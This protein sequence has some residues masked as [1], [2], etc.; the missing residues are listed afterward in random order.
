MNTLEIPVK[1]IFVQYP[2]DWNE[3]TQKQAVFAGDLLYKVSNQKIDI[4]QFRKLMVDKFIRRVNNKAPSLNID[5]ELDLWGN[6]YLLAETVN[7][8]FK[9]TKTGEKPVQRYRKGVVK[10]Q[11]K[12]PASDDD[13]DIAGQT[14]P[15]ADNGDITNGKE[16]WEVMPTLT[17]NP[18]PWCKTGLFGK[19]LYGPGDFLQ[20][21]TFAEYKDALA[22]S[23]KYMDT[24]NDEWLDRL[25]AILYRKKITGLKRLMKQPDFDGKIRVPY[26]QN[27]TDV[28]AVKHVKTGIKYMA[29][30]YMMGCLWTL[31]NTGEGNE[32]EIDGNKF[33]FSILFTGGK[34]TDDNNDTVGMIGVMMAIAES[35]VF[36]NLK[37]VA[38]TDVWDVLV[39][40][41]QL[42]LDRREFEKRMS[43]K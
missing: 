5:D 12:P 17:K 18:I 13:A 32:I 39:R 9:I 27:K 1:K 33:D 40:M 29:L 4:D 30:M 24:N 6:D 23:M 37:D 43:E 2:S 42:E 11:D 34:N 3:L 41:Y 36:G 10:T 15:D 31:K 22:A 26:N 14:Y 21:M 8:F 7:F 19:K 38:N 28:K 16:T 35:G 20:G 25:T